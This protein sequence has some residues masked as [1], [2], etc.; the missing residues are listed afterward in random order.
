MTPP[1]YGIYLALR[2]SP[3]YTFG[4]RRLTH[5]DITRRA[6]FLIPM[7]LNQLLEALEKRGIAEALLRGGEPMQMRIEGEWKPQGAPFPVGALGAML[8]SGAPPDA[9]TQW[10]TENRCQFEQNGY[11]IK[12]ARR[13]DRVQ[14]AVK[15]AAV[16]SS[17][18]TASSEGS[19]TSQTVFAP[20]TSTV[21]KA[22]AAK[23]PLKPAVIDW[24]Y[25]DAGAEKGP[26]TPN[27][28]RVL[29]D[30]GVLKGD[31]LVWCDG[32]ADW[33]PAR[34]SD[35]RP[36]LPAG[37]LNPVPVA[38]PLS[39]VA[40]IASPTVPRS[41]PNIGGG[42]IHEIPPSNEKFSIGAFALP[43]FWCYSNGQGSRFWPIFWTGFIPCVGGLVSLYLTIQLAG[44][45]NS[46]AW[47]SR[48]WDSVEHF[49]KTQRVWTIV[50][51]VMILLYVGLFFSSFLLGMNEPTSY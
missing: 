31:T 13:D 44:E 34:D 2:Q 25:L 7:K 39:P 14:I 28:M 48:E 1:V 49:E 11:V 42:R 21:A 9:L 4:G 43:L 6:G 51:W 41:S 24:F 16:S 17:P 26:V 36:M 37:A 18:F 30:T 46:L 22:P 45:A 19:A 40:P 35:V 20:T 12:A 33:L 5:L 10:Q 8:E 27:Q 3:R 47:V 15:R 23:A 38:P 50:G 29:A 32:M